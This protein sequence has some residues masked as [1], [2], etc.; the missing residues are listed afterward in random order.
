MAEQYPVP[1]EQLIKRLMSLHRKGKLPASL[2]ITGEKGVGKWLM[3]RELARAITCLESQADVEASCA[4]CRQC[5]A[6]SHPDIHYLFPLP[7]DA[8]RREKEKSFASYVEA[9]ESNPFGESPS[10]V[11][12]FIPIDAIRDFQS[13]LARKPSLSPHKIGIVYEAERMLPAAMDS[14]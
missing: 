12:Q 4:S 9:K 8:K 5:R 10:E 3:V 14:L 2:L 7:G 6:F 11:T 13:S 1:Q